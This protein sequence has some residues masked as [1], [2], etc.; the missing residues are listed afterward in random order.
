[1]VVLHAQND[2]ENG[3]C[4]DDEDDDYL[5]DLLAFVHSVG[6]IANVVAQLGRVCVH[7]RV[8]KMSDK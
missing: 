8:G 6:Y 2:A 5:E 4:R 7:V 1:M 3:A